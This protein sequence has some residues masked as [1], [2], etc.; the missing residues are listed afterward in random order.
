[1]HV[2][3]LIPSTM[4]LVFSI[5]IYTF[6]EYFY[7]IIY[8]Y[9]QLLFEYMHLLFEF[10]LPVRRRRPAAST[11]IDCFCTGSLCAVFYILEAVLYVHGNAW[12]RLSSIRP[13]SNGST[14]CSTVF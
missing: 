4:P 3:S 6:K 1:M 14:T 7:Y 8:A 12:R 10:G 2:P 11:D 5:H 9:M 13:K